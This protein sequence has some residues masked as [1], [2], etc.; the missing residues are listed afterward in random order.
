MP[1]KKLQSSPTPPVPLVG[2]LIRFLIK[3]TATPL[4]GPIEKEAIR[5][6]SSE[7]SM[8]KKLGT[9]GRLKLRNISTVAT[10][11]KMAVMAIFRTL[12]FFCTEPSLSE[13]FWFAKDRWGWRKGAKNPGAA[14]GSGSLFDEGEI[15]RERQR[16][17]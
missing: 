6:G 12:A 5:A 10:A 1:I 16:R 4:T 3:H 17:A 9:M 13:K 15:Q 11:L 14:Q 7:K 2:R 8:A